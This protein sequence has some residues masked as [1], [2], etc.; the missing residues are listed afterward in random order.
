MPVFKPFRG[1]RPHPD[2]IDKFPTHPLDNFTQEEINKKATEDSSYIQ[3][4]KPYVCSKSKD[5]DRNLRKV[6][7][8]TKKCW[9]TI[10]FFKTA[11]LIICMSKFYPINLFSEAY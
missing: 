2:Y 8:I 9:V 6:E 7:A 11:L 5:V 4:I 10:N 3:M 1:V